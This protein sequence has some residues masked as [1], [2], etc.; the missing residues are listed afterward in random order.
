MQG[1]HQA[2][3]DAE[4]DA[5]EA[6][7]SQHSRAMLM[8][9]DEAPPHPTTH[10]PN[11][12]RDSRIVQ[13]GNAVWG[14][15]HG[16]DSDT[17]TTT[18]SYYE[19]E[20]TD[21]EGLAL[22]DGEEA[23]DNDGEENEPDDDEEEAIQMEMDD[24]E[25][26]TLSD[27]DD[28][29]ASP[30]QRPARIHLRRTGGYRSRATPFPVP[31]SWRPALSSPRRESGPSSPSYAPPSQWSPQT[32]NLAPSVAALE[33]HAATTTEGSALDDLLPRTQSHELRR[34]SR[35]RRRQ[36]SGTDITLQTAQASSS[37]PRAGLA[38][39]QQCVSLQQ[40]YLAQQSTDGAAAMQPPAPTCDKAVTAAVHAEITKKVTLVDAVLFRTAFLQQ[41]VS[42]APSGR[43]LDEFTE[44]GESQ[45][46]GQRPADAAR[47]G[48]WQ[49]LPLPQ[50]Q[51]ALMDVFATLPSAEPM[52][53][54][55]HE[56]PVRGD[57][58]VFGRGN[59]SSVVRNTRYGRG[60]PSVAASYNEGPP[61][62]VS[63]HRAGL[64]VQ[65]QAQNESSA[66]TAF[67]DVLKQP[68]FDISQFFRSLNT[69][70]D[71]LLLAERF[72]DAN[73][74]MATLRQLRSL[75]ASMSL[76]HERRQRALAGPAA[77]NISATGVVD[78]ASGSSQLHNEDAHS[79]ASVMSAAPLL[80]PRFAAL[81]K[82]VAASLSMVMRAT[83]VLCSALV[84]SSTIAAVTNWPHHGP[85]LNLREYG[86]WSS[87]VPVLLRAGNA[88]DDVQPWVETASLQY[89]FELCGIKVTLS[90]D[91]SFMPTPM[92][93]SAM[94]AVRGTVDQRQQLPLLLLA[95]AMDERFLGPR[96]DNEQDLSAADELE[97][98]VALPSADDRQQVQQ[99]MRMRQLARVVAPLLRA[100]IAH[101][102]HYYRQLQATGLSGDDETA[103]RPEFP[104][105]IDLIIGECFGKLAQLIAQHPIRSAFDKTWTAMRAAMHTDAT[106]PG[107]L[108]P[109][110]D[111]AAGCAEACD[112]L[113]GVWQHVDHLIRAVDAT[114]R[115]ARTNAGSYIHRHDEAYEC[116]VRHLGTRLHRSDVFE[117]LIRVFSVASGPALLKVVELLIA[118]LREPERFPTFDTPDL[119]PLQDLEEGF[120]EIMRASQAQENRNSVFLPIILQQLSTLLAVSSAAAD[121]FRRLTAVQVPVVPYASPA[122][123]SRSSVGSPSAG[124]LPPKRPQ[125]MRQLSYN[126]KP[127]KIP[128]IICMSAVLRFL[129]LMEAHEPLPRDI[130]KEALALPFIG[131][132]STIPSRIIHTHPLRV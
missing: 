5:Q 52:S 61:S 2:L 55:R 42:R 94:P 7:D 99:R 46:P 51:Q 15:E 11:P 109:D 106:R 43:I 8:G 122:L 126:A 92:H 110:S 93:R 4:A 132:C 76:V 26:F 74:L 97:P 114:Q 50:R 40:A 10:A 23:G 48:I 12:P 44:A 125:L 131:M 118:L 78:S 21:V 120:Q 25:G 80:P 89:V 45:H 13:M 123:R 19:D 124:E 41:V 36:T 117:L 3:L 73:T 130:F 39:L 100:D 84:Q 70:P 102:T 35:A 38:T 96:E 34:L 14:S 28:V 98:H 59:G 27:G 75:R 9:V 67:A 62:V 83:S 113:W 101:L 49:A 91:P 56:S 103:P 32:Q 60:T 65:T 54:M 29:R 107:I 81:P 18:D 85:T 71:V 115:A 30:W 64:V 112:T 86:G 69:P 63:A 31:S 104:L 66:S 108:P 58:S 121:V 16:S 68:A 77:L 111:L 128:S 47:A 119:R 20:D 1:W 129:R 72:T 127:G 53:F 57:N 90:A 105:V 82:A 87:L 79:Y 37:S 6:E 95:G 33:R 88:A 116:A 22:E 17:T 24:D